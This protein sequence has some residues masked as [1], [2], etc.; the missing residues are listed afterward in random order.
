MDWKFKHFNQ[1]AVFNA[2]VSDVL[3]AA[4]ATLAGLFEQ[5]EATPDGFVAR[6]YSGWHAATATFRLASI[7]EGT[8]LSVE[9]LVERSTMRG[10]M[11]FD[12]GGYYNVQIDKWF[13]G[14]AGRLNLAGEQALVSKTTSDYRIRQGCF[15]GCVVWLAVGTCLGMAGIALDRALLPQASGTAT[16][17]FSLLSSTLALLA[18]VA[19]FLYVRYPDAPAS[20]SVRER[21]QRNRDK[22]SS[23]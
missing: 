18:G 17:P 13:A 5:I 23:G 3:E 12:V 1:H 16:G 22:N 11:L 14:I 2:P 15:A 7:A 9:L 20:K 21:L 4:R 6:G 10:Y 8:R 19:V